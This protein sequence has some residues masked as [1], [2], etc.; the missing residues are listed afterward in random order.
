MIGE[1]GL[2]G[3]GKS[4]GVSVEARGTTLIPIRV[5]KL[6]STDEIESVCEAIWK[7]SRLFLVV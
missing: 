2:K 3:V 7:G 4:A 1:K 6:E 5:S